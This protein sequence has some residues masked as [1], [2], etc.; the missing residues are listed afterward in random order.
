[1]RRA[2]EL[3]AMVLGS[4]ILALVVCLILAGIS[5]SGVLT[6]ELTRIFFWI[7]LA[8]AIVGTVL[9]LLLMSHPKKVAVIGGLCAAALLGSGL[10]GLDTWLHK[11]KAE[12]D[13]ANK[14]PVMLAQINPSPAP[15]VLS[16]TPKSWFAPTVSNGN[17]FGNTVRG[18]NNTVTGAI[19]CPGGIC[20]GRDINFVPPPPPPPTIKV[21]VSDSTLED[22]IYSTVITFATNVQVFQP[23]FLMSFDKPVG[24]GDVSI[25]FHPLGM[26][27]GIRLPKIPHPENSIGFRIISIDMSR[28]I[29]EPEDGLI[30]AKV[31]SQS[32]VK[33]LKVEG[34]RGEGNIVHFDKI[35]LQCDK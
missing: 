4:A 15:K 26:N 33:L 25:G 2:V 29:W 9:G 6:M 16:K 3:V 14:P 35:V 22:S 12:Q 13:A 19:N 17:V 23:G 27:A 31:T 20:A 11:K 7:A 1:V 21:C 5:A 10:I 34:G 18:N 24:Y 30:T 28:S 32:P 8:I